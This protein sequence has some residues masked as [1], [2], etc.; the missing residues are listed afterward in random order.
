MRDLSNIWESIVKYNLDFGGLRQLSMGTEGG[1]IKGF[2]DIGET[3]RGE[4]WRSYQSTPIALSELKVD[5][6]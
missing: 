6:R 1:G 3:R 2:F 5:V 4:I